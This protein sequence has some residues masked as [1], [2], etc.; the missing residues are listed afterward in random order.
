MIF[1]TLRLLHILFFR[2]LGRLF[3]YFF[4]KRR[5]IA[6]E[7][8]KRCYNFLQQ[9]AK[10]ALPQNARAKSYARKITKKSFSNLGH[11][12]ADFLLL[13]YYTKKN[14]DRYVKIKN[15]SY[16]E[17]ALSNGKGVILST[18]HFGSWELAAHC[19][20]LKGFKSLIIYNKFKK[21]VWLDD[22]VKRQRE[23]SGN[24]LI[25]K[26]NSFLTLYKCLKKNGIVVLVTDQ[27]AAPPDGRQIS[28]LGQDDAWT[29]T[30]FVKMS[31]KT[32]APIVPVY[33]FVDGVSKYT[34]EFFKP[35][36]PKSFASEKDPVY[37]MARACNASLEEVILRAP[38]LWMWQHRRFKTHRDASA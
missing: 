34:I 1:A 9:G 16:L 24:T 19:L 2:T 17:E 7:N 4:K 25:L 11:N 30:T 22:V 29:H 18:G 14:I 5:R 6:M 21:P 10:S 28:F 26:E 20:A 38:H 13:K 27:H 8:V 37:A 32:G 15:R 23:Y 3:F 33:S 31:I 12:L 35:I 36:D